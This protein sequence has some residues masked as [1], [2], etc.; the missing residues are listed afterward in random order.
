MYV[1]IATIFIAELIIAG[2]II[3]WLQ[4]FRKSV[5]FTM[6]QAAEVEVMT[7]GTI[8]QFRKVMKS[9]QGLIGNYINFFDKKK[10]E[11]RNKILHLILIY[12]IL[13]LCKTKFKRAATI[14]HYALLIK[15][16][17]NSIPV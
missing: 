6:K 14:L 10:H 11:I 17:W 7:I 2:F 3:Y 4:K 5:G 1:F 12:L 13:I 8:K 16:F 15:D 9:T